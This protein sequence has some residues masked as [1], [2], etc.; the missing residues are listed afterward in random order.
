MFR[1]EKGAFLA[2]RERNG[3]NGLSPIASA[4]PIRMNDK[5]YTDRGV[6]SRSYLL[7]R[8]AL[9]ECDRSSAREKE[10][11]ESIDLHREFFSCDVCTR[12]PANDLLSCGRRSLDARFSL[13]SGEAH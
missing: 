5:D 11:E 4:K 9:A 6:L 2:D 12:A 3:Q 1:Q 8:N 7:D 13:S 10:K